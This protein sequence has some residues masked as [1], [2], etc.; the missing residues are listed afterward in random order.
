MRWMFTC[1][2]ESKGRQQPKGTEG[3]EKCYFSKMRAQS[4]TERKKLLD[5]AFKNHWGQIPL[6]LP[7]HLCL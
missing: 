3:G 1:Q 7:K 5:K 4:L 6:K 2:R